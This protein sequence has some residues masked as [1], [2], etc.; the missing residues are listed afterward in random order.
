MD[1]AMGVLTPWAFVPHLFLSHTDRM[2]FYQRAYNTYLSLYDVVIRHCLG[3]YI[4]STDVPMR[5]IKLLLDAFAQLKQNVLWKYENRNLTKELPPNV[6]IYNWLP[7]NDIFAHPNVKLFISQGGIF[8]TQEAIYWGLPLLFIPFFGDQ[9]RNAKKAVRAGYARLLMFDKMTSEDL[10]QNIQTLIDD[11]RY[12][13]EAMVASRLFRDNPIAPLKEATFWLEY[14]LRHKGAPHLKSH[15]AFMSLYQY[16]LLDVL[17]CTILFLIL[18]ISSMACVVVGIKRYCLRR[19]QVLEARRK[20][21]K[22][23]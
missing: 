3:T 14:V 18:I 16:L 15:G 22:R 5:K 11:P 10:V 8:S 2:N 17:G 9:H 23:N 1:H 12:K 13:R 4:Q 6:K 20:E 19:R 7:Q 21:L